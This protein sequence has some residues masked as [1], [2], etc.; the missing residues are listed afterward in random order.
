MSIWVCSSRFFSRL[1]DAKLTVNLT[2]CEF[3]K[4]TLAYLAK[5]IG[6]G[7]VCPVAAKVMA[8][9][10]FP[11]PA[12]QKQLWHFLGMVGYYRAFCKNVAIVVSPLSD[13]LSPKT[14]FQWSDACQCAFENVKSLLISAPVLMII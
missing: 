2:K 3:G 11:P 5:V 12:D 10:D 13:L 4:A 1:A 14:L 7:Q 6:G 9:C 8:I